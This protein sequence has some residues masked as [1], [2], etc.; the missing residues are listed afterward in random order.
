MGL[1]SCVHNNATSVLKRVAE[2]KLR[3]LASVCV[4]EAVYDTLSDGVCYSDLITVSRDASGN[5]LGVFSNSLQI[6]RIARDVAHL[7]Q[8]NLTARANEGVDVPLGAFTGVEAWAGFGPPIKLQTISVSNV[9]SK[10]SS[11]FVSAGVN[12]TKHAIYIE[13]VAEISLITTAG[14]NAFST[15]S[16]VL[17]AESVLLGKVPEAYL[18]GNIFGKN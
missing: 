9:T 8:N 14:T 10:F 15:Q 1:S 5:I 17:I 7:S 16:E 11:T 13:V 3:A 12:Q 2:A 18:N 6:N 4:N